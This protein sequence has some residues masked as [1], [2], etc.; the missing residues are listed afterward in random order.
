MALLGV[1][2]HLPNVL[3][4]ANL[5]AEMIETAVKLNPHAIRTDRYTLWLQG[6]D[7][8]GQIRQAILAIRNSFDTVLSD[9]GHCCAGYRK[10]VR[11]LGF[12]K[13]VCLSQGPRAANPHKG[14]GPADEQGQEN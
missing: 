4:L 14:S 8:R 3:S 11:I 1:V 13:M 6:G 12:T 2:A 5:E 7:G 9:C 10:L